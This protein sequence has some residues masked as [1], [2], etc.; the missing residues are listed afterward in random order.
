MG[1]MTWL[2][3]VLAVLCRFA[4]LAEHFE[5]NDRNHNLKSGKK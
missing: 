2:M 3:V 1:Q 5:W 4:L